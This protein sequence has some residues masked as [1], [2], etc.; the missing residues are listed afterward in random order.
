MVLF[1]FNKLNILLLSNKF[2]IFLAKTKYT[3]I[4]ILV[5]IQCVTNH[6]EVLLGID[7]IMNSDSILS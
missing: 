4:S 7:N 5:L 1:V 6:Y 2:Y 3:L